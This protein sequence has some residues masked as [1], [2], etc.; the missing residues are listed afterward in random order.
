MTH[1]H[2]FGMRRWILNTLPVAFVPI[3]VF[4]VILIWATC[5]DV[6]TRVQD[7]SAFSRLARDVEFRTARPADTSSKSDVRQFL[8]ARLMPTLSKN[9]KRPCKRLLLIILFNKPGFYN[10]VDFLKRSYESV[11]TNVCCLRAWTNTTRRP[12]NGSLCWL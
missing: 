2:S 3:G 11:F 1:R 9:Q 12:G 10:N 8:P 7:G 5:A 6:G 4:V